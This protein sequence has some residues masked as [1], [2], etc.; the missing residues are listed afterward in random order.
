MLRVY[1][2]PGASSTEVVR[3]QGEGSGARVKIRLAAP[4]VD[5]KANAALRAFLAAAFG[6]PLRCVTLVRGETGRGKTVRIAAP[7]QRP[8]REWR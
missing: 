7:R 8:D 5:G 3:I 6:V 4:A 2:Q 1:A